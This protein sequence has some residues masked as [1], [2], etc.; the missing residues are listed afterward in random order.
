MNAIKPVSDE[1]KKKSFEKIAQVRIYNLYLMTQI[2]DL[3]ISRGAFRG[4]EASQVGALFDILS[5]AVN[6]AYD[7]TIAE[8]EENK[9]VNEIKTSFINEDNTN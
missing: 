2:I 4:A 9:K 6:K 5:S 3:A 1:I 8:Q 7:I